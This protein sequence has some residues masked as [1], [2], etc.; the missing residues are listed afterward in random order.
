MRERFGTANSGRPEHQGGVRAYPQKD[1]WLLIKSVA[2]AIPTYSMSCFLGSPATCTTSNYW[3][4]SKVDRRGLHWRRWPELTLP[5][6]HGGMGFRDIKLFNIAML[7]KQGWRLMT[8]QSSL[9]V[10]LF[11]DGLVMAVRLPTFGMIAGFQG[12]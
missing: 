9:E 1:L 11:R 10:G 5:K 8:Y 6:C 12:Q 2:Q 3:W 7:G 4:S